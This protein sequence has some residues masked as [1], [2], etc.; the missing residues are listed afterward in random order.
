MPPHLR[1]TR[2]VLQSRLITTSVVSGR[3]RASSPDAQM[4]KSMP[5]WGSGGQSSRANCPLCASY[6][7]RDQVKSRDRVKLVFKRKDVDAWQPPQERATFDSVFSTT[8]SEVSAGRDV[9]C[10]AKRDRGPGPLK[11][12]RMFSLFLWRMR[13]T[14]ITCQVV[15]K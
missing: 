9:T 2:P 5:A 14:I 15:A 4:R 7:S 13:N 10:D 8:A 3:A 12:G 11:S 1:T 6:S